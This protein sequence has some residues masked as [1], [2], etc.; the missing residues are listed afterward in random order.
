MAS[1]LG[2]KKGKTTVGGFGRRFDPY[3]PIVP[4]GTYDPALDSQLGAAQRGYGNL[5]EDAATQST[6][7]LADLTFG[8]AQ[9]GQGYDRNVADLTQSRDRGL[10]DLG[11]NRTR[12]TEDY[13]RNVQMLQ[14][15]YQQLAGRQQE[16]QNAA[17][18]LKGGAV[19]QAA[20][21][22][23]ANE[24]IDRQ[25]LDTNFQRF[26]QDIDLQTGRLN[27]DYGTQF[28]RLGEDRTS[29]LS[30]LALGASRGQEDAATQL[31][32]GG[33]ELGQ[34]GLDIGAQK[35]YQATQTGY[36]PPT[37]PSNE[38]RDKNGN[39]YR[40]IMVGKR[41]VRIGPDGRPI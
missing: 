2:I 10:A 31:R 7:T 13:N 41:K 38:F 1:R 19:L 17:G 23:K 32:R 6:R 29:S 15:S 18:V 27:Q 4:A 24:A 8:Q 11:T 25:P 37:K 35:L 39:P 26:G 30:Q 20:A 9:V 40:V 28:G 12:G 16:Q 33:V 3:S 34:Y 14:R 21:K 5:Q 22:R 36:V